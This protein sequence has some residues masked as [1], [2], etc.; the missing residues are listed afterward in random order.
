[1]EKH[2][3]ACII[4]IKKL[5]ESDNEAQLLIGSQLT[6]VNVGTCFKTSENGWVEDHK[7]IH[8]KGNT[9]TAVLLSNESGA[10]RNPDALVACSLV[11]FT[12]ENL[13]LF[14]KHNTQVF[15][16]IFTI[17][18]ANVGGKLKANSKKHSASGAPKPSAERVK[19]SKG[20]SRVVYVG[21]RGGKYIK[22]K[23]KFVRV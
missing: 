17:L 13:N 10:S 23:G 21:P 19:D 22:S 5:G 2:G 4:A 11:T 1:M 15:P 3:E 12:I 20:R 7:I 14:D 16:E 6:T 8:I 9:L 18:D